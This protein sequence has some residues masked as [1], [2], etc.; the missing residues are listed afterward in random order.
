MSEIALACIKARWLI[1]GAQC[2]FELFF[3]YQ[4]SHRRAVADPMESGFQGLL[5][6]AG[7]EFSLAWLKRPGCEFQSVF[8]VRSCFLPSWTNSAALIW[9]SGSLLFRNSSMAV[10]ARSDGVL[11]LLGAGDFN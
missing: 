9:P 4:Y 1:R 8:Y 11:R 7:D 6:P 2:G 10:R 3:G 5:E